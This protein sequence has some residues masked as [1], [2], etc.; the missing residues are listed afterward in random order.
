M[1]F[2]AFAL[3]CPA[4][5]LFCWFDYTMYVIFCPV[6]ILNVPLYFKN[7]ETRSESQSPQ[8]SIGIMPHFSIISQIISRIISR[9]IS[10]II[11]QII[12]YFR[13]IDLGPIRQITGYP[14]AFCRRLQDQITIGFRL[15]RQAGKATL[16]QTV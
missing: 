14:Q 2:G 15:R 12:F 16:C 1:I 7:T 8:Y 13:L 10:Q 4:S 3:R 11:S 9:I 6:G 5:A